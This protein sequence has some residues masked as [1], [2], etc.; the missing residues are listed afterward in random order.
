MKKI[1]NAINIAYILLPVLLMLTACKD[2]PPVKRSSGHLTPVPSVIDR[3]I[4]NCRGN[5]ECI[6]NCRGRWSPGYAPPSETANKWNV[7]VSEIYTNRGTGTVIGVPGQHAVEYNVEYVVKRNSMTGSQTSLVAGSDTIEGAIDTTERSVE[8]GVIVC[9][10]MM[11]DNRRR[12]QDDGQELIRV[13]NTGVTVTPPLQGGNIR[14]TS[15]NDPISPFARCDEVGYSAP[16]ERQQTR[17]GGFRQLKGTSG[18]VIQQPYIITVSEQYNIQVFNI[19]VANQFKGYVLNRN[20]SIM[21]QTVNMIE[22]ENID[23]IRG[24]QTTFFNTV[25]H[26]LPRLTVRYAVAGCQD[27]E[28]LPCTNAA[29]VVGPLFQNPNLVTDLNGQI[30]I[31]NRP[32]TYAGPWKISSPALNPAYLL[33]LIMTQFQRDNPEFVKSSQIGNLGTNLFNIIKILSNQP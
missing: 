18:N 3:C 17:R 7:E 9:R 23:Y 8:K 4:A 1:I 13:V 20:L 25:Q 33:Q 27:N 32:F 26:H 11:D 15:T 5:T 21:E 22:S 24:Q 14:Y 19:K 10:C 16:Q 30:S 12:A 28:C 2:T 29:T 6:D 31:Q